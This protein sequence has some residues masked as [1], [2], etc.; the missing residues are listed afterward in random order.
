M[1]QDSPGLPEVLKYRN[2]WVCGVSACFTVAF[3]TIGVGFLPLYLTN[4]RHFLPQQMGLL[5][6]AL[7][8]SGALLGI[9]LPAISDRIGRKPVVITASLLGIL[10]PLS[11]M[12]FHGTIAFLA[13]LL[14]IGW[15]PASAATLLFATI[16]CESVPARS[17]STAL[18]LIIAVS[19]LAGGV[20]GPMVAGWSADRWGLSAPL[21]LEMGCC[22]VIAVLSLT[23]R[24][25]APHFDRDVVSRVA[26]ARLR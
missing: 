1:P 5:M 21:F 10:Y 12:N 16:P 24:E 2:V 26:Q 8:I 14:F 19:T 4:V 3:I 25:T 18:G 6:S 17:M 9:A 7:G 13:A 23:L 20:A 11:V 15:A 22:A